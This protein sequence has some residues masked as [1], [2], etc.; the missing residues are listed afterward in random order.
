M[1]AAVIG[2]PVRPGLPKRNSSSSVNLIKKGTSVKARAKGKER[3]GSTSTRHS[4]TDSKSYSR[5]PAS[6]SRAHST[7]SVRGQFAS[8]LSNGVSSLADS[9]RSR[10][11]GGESSTGKKR[12]EIGSSL[13]KSSPTGAHIQKQYF[14]VLPVPAAR[15][16][17]VIRRPL[18]GRSHTIANL[19]RLN[20]APETLAAVPSQPQP[21]APSPRPKGRS[22]IDATSSDLE[23]TSDED[24]SSVWSS[25]SDD[26]DDLQIGNK[27]SKASQEEEE[28][29]HIARQAA[30]EAARQREMFRK[31]PSRSYSNLGQRKQ[32]GLLTT[33]LNPDPSLL[34]YLSTTSI[35]SEGPWRQRN[36]AL[37]LG[38]P[39]HIP[40]GPSQPT[41]TAG[42]LNRNSDFCFP[43]LMM[44]FS[45]SWCWTL[46]NICSA[47]AQ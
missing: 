15:E 2:A 41:T 19:S 45:S 18:P 38:G 26:E 28:T 30:L 7:N 39:P 5:S 44:I 20:P 8:P 16:M 40:S 33:L 36:S 29:G 6:H 34:P 11:S 35:Q 42:A 37:S 21:Q 32:S 1:A 24:G 9:G 3:G 22:L 46:A 12:I 43:R 23:T 4:S 14:R 31:L 17:A 25:V 13:K 47:E 27:R 10:Q